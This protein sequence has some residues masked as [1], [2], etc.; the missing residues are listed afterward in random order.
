MHYAS[1]LKI[2]EAQEIVMF[3]VVNNS[4]DMV[5]KNGETALHLCCG[6]QPNHEFAKALVMAGASL[7]I[8]NALGE[9]PITLA[10]RFGNHDLTN[11][12]LQQEI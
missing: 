12:F 11:L 9:T 3:A 6:K 8:K 1:K 10:K 7:Q 2:Q 4:I 5:N